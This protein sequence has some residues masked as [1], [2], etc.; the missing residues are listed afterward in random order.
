MIDRYC[1]PIPN[2]HKISIA[3]E[4]T[5]L[6]NNPIPINIGNGEQFQDAFL[7]DLSVSPDLGNR[8]SRWPGWQPYPLMWTDVI[9]V[10]SPVQEGLEVLADR[11]R[12]QPIGDAERGV[13]FSVTQYQ[14]R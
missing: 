14:R 8:R 6:F 12:A 5:G 1:W 2:G 4:E 10:R 13:M 3:M 7:L 11:R 9:A